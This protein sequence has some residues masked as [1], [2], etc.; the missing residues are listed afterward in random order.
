MNNKKERERGNYV[1]YGRLRI[2]SARIA[3][4]TTIAT[5]IITDSG[6]KYWSANDVV[7]VVGEVVACA[8]ISKFMW[9]CADEVK[10]ELDPANVAV[11][12]YVPGIGGV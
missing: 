8:G 12:A 11:I 5:M 10:Y 7:G 9:V 1:F 6:M 3:P 2:I 4:M